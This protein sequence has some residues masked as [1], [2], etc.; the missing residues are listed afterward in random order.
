MKNW[1][2]TVL[3][4]L[5][6]MIITTKW[7]HVLERFILKRNQSFDQIIDHVQRGY[8]QELI[9]IV[10]KPWSIFIP[11]TIEILEFKVK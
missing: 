6:D 3:I 7:M 4:N 8:R 5:F 1:Y 9:K 10:Q 11:S 2:N